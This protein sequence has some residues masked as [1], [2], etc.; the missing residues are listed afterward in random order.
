ME[1]VRVGL[2]AGAVVAFLAGPGPMALPAWGACNVIPAP[3]SHPFLGWL[4]AVDTALG[5]PDAPDPVPTPDPR[6]VEVAGSGCHATQV[7]GEDYYVAVLFD[8]PRGGAP[9]MVFLTAAEDCAPLSPAACD[10]RGDL[11]CVCGADAALEVDDAADRVRFRFPD[12]P[13]AGSA[14]LAVLAYTE[15][16]PWTLTEMRCEKLDRSD[17]MFACIDALYAACST[18]AGE[19]P[20]PLHA[21]FPHF[22]A[23][24]PM[25]D[26]ARVCEDPPDATPATPPCQGKGGPLAL[27]VDRAGNALLPVRWAGVLA[28]DPKGGGRKNRAV[29]GRT[30][31]PRTGNGTA[32]IRIPDDAFL[33]S[34]T[35]QGR[36]WPDAPPFT[37]RDEAPMLVLSGDAD[38]PESVLRIAR[39]RPWASWCQ[40]G[41]DDGQACHPDASQDCRGAGAA[42]VARTPA[43]YFACDGG[44][45]SGDYCTR[46]GDCPGAACRP[47]A[48][49][50][51]VETGQATG[52]MC[53]TGD[54]CDPY[55]QECGL[56]LF[57]LRGRQAGGVGPVPIPKGQYEARAKEYRPRP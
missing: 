35:P 51:D 39:S 10:A 17:G 38:E 7:T 32:H 19:E 29:E 12:T 50:H 40:G 27:A 45:N 47:L 22:T 15:P 57:E 44:Q 30:S 33:A 18:E 13:Y 4:G 2:V 11:H 5:R 3:S 34:F 36:G 43:W 1:S 9:N 53:K 41:T 25:N 26:W 31:F 6:L 52:T 54:E 56:G 28:D 46:R 20:G 42:C 48:R 37:A 24:P 14:T 21:H 55:D 8:P 16:L 23:L 49:C